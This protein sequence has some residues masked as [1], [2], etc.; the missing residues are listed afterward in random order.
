M[1]FRSLRANCGGIEMEQTRQAYRVSETAQ[2]LGVTSATIRRWIK[3]GDLAATK[4]GGTPLIPQTEIARV[5]GVHD[6]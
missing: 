6:V 1:T 2:I 3:L 4:V 5:L